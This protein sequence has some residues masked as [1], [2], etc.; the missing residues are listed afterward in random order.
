[1]NLP[2][3]S[4]TLSSLFGMAQ[5]RQ[6]RQ[7]ETAFPAKVVSFDSAE[8]SVDVEPAFT[9]VFRENENRKS[10]P[11][12]T[13]MGVPV[14]YQRA[15]GFSLYMPVEKGDWVLVVC[16]KYSL[17]KWWQSK[18]ANQDPGDMGRF[19]LNG[20]VAI[21]GLFPD[22]PAPNGPGNNSTAVLEVP[23]GKELWL[24]NGASSF[25]ALANKVNAELSA[26]WDLLSGSALYGT[27]WTP[28]PTPDSGAALIAAA[29]ARVTAGYPGDVDSDKVKSE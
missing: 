20:A 22:T 8:Q 23:G 21:P 1:M 9:Q 3:E 10:V 5:D 26:I 25:I 12:P 29:T 24:G 16:C 19:S 11:Y 14:I 2:G 13:L 4:V 7:M 18:E 28:S 27:K 17:D 6:E 15:G